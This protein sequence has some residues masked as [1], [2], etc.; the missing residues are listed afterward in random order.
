MA[1]GKRQILAEL[2]KVDVILI[3]GDA[4]AIKRSVSGN[5]Y[6]SMGTKKRAYVFN[7]SSLADEGAITGYKS[8]FPGL[9]IDAFFT[10]CI[11]QKGI[12]EVREY[13]KRA[14]SGFR[15]NREVRAMACGIPNVGKSM[16]INAL[17]KRSA[18]RT[19]NRPAVTRGL[20]WIRV[21]GSFYLLDTPGILEPSLSGPGDAF[22]LSAIGSVKDTGY[23][24]EELAYAIIAF[25]A[26]RYPSLL[27]E[28]YKLEGPFGEAAQTF[29]AIGRN[30][31]FLR[32]GGEI[33]EVRTADAI[34]DDF[35]NGR[36]G[37]V[38]FDFWEGTW[39]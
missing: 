34:V 9:G 22:A 3:V 5:F 8:A 16:L 19:E 30:R 29:A 24:T 35:K 10:D 23:D 27:S 7:K 17:A 32:K 13:L 21:E 12:R 33:D 25:M 4:R 39:L 26:A 38:A 6:R 31:G 1:K 20:K 37:K 15:F 28:R 14:S 11:E 18:N 36:I 2:A